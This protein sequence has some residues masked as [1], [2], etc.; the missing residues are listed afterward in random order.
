[1]NTPQS[2]DS[3]CLL[4]LVG[5]LPACVLLGAG[6]FFAIAVE[7]A[8]TINRLAVCVKEMLRA[9]KTSRLA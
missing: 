8:H 5:A 4:T 3:P 2:P 7:G 9:R 1:M 6:L